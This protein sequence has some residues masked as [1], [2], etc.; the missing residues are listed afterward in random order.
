MAVPSSGKLELYGD[1]GTELGVAQSNVT[2]HG[3]SQTAGFSTPDAMSEFYGYSPLPPQPPGTGALVTTSN[4]GMFISVDD[5]A[6]WSQDAIV[7]TFSQNPDY[8][9]WTGSTFVCNSGNKLHYSADGYNWTESF[10]LPGSNVGG[11]TSNGTTT[12]VGSFN[13]SSNNY[14]HT[15]T[16]GGITWTQRYSSNNSMTGLRP[17]G[18]SPT[19]YSV[20]G[21]VNGSWTSSNSG[22]SWS[23]S[24]NSN[25]SNCNIGWNNG[26]WVAGSARDAGYRWST[27]ATPGYP[28][29]WNVVGGF[30]PVL[31]TYM[32]KI[33]GNGSTIALFRTS[34]GTSRVYRST[35][36]GA[37]GFSPVSYFSSFPSSEP[38]YHNNKFFF[39]LNGN[40]VSSSDGNTWSVSSSN[41]GFDGYNMAS[42]GKLNY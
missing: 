34:G 20:W 18:I 26:V 22:A 4:L 21:W 5:G 37:G 15:S 16:D 13:S 28:T 3:M 6:S 14:W 2:L 39:F 31:S 30:G 10:T 23:V 8:V 17:G 12:I 40:C 27:S 35:S 29:G 36:S 25:G 38:I 11:I 33:A 42:M 1:I 41:V 7:H 9:T 32:G 24:Y 19:G